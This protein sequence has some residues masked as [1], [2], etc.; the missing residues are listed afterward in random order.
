MANIATAATIAKPT[1]HRPSWATVSMS[2]PR[3]STSDC[4]RA[5]GAASSHA[6]NAPATTTSTAM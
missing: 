6:P 1:S 2:M 3:P 5:G 4:R